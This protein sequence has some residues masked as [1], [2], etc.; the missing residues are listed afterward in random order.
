L[1]ELGSRLVAA[2]S[3]GLAEAMVLAAVQKTEQVRLA[4][5]R[6]FGDFVEK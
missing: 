1:S 2:M 5:V 3:R 6:Q 4:P